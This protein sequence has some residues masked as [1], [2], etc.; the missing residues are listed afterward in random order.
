MVAQERSSKTRI[1]LD[2]YFIRDGALRLTRLTWCGGPFDKRTG[3]YRDNV[4]VTA[5]LV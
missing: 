4:V 3:H 5:S 2:K 1:P